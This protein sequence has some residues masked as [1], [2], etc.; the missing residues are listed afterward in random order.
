M[1]TNAFHE[2]KA[3][4]AS[5]EDTLQEQPATFRCDHCGEPFK[6]GEGRDGY[7]FTCSVHVA[8]PCKDEA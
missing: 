5:S 3:A 7:C 2:S 8:C 6:A 1:T 4:S